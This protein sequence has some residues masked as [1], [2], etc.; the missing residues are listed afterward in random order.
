[1]VLVHGPTWAIMGRDCWAMGR[2][3]QVAACNGGFG[4]VAV[5]QRAGSRRTWPATAGFGG[6]TV[7]QRVGSRGT[8]PMTAGVGDVA[9]G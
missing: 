1:M 8:W 5:G 2:F 9:V 7:E 3:S 4:D 6:A